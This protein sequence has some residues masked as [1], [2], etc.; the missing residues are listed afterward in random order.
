MSERLPT[1]LKPPRGYPRGMSNGQSSRVM[2]E[3]AQANIEHHGSAQGWWEHR[4]VPDEKTPW[5][6][7]FIPYR[8]SL[9]DASQVSLCSQPVTVGESLLSS[10]LG[11]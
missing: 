6:L 5:H 11:I 8:P 4:N 2:S 3:D 7:K 9:D 1:N 10:K